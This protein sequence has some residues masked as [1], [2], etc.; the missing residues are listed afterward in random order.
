A[1]RAKLV[2]L[3]VTQDLL[4]ASNSEAKIRGKTNTR[5][6]PHSGTKRMAEGRSTQPFNSDGAGKGI[7]EV[8]TLDRK[9]KTR[10]VDWKRLLVYNVSELP[11]SYIKEA[12][13]KHTSLS[14]H[15]ISV[16]RCCQRDGIRRFDVVPLTRVKPTLEDLPRL[17][18][19]LRARVKVGKS[20]T[21]RMELARRKFVESGVLVH[22]PS[23][24]KVE[25]PC[26]VSF[27]T[28]NI[29]GLRLKLSECALLL[30]C[31]KPTIVCLQETLVKESA[32]RTWLPHYQTIETRAK[33]GSVRGMALAVMRDSGLD[34]S[35]YYASDWLLVGR[36]T[37]SL[38]GNVKID[39]LV[40]N[41]YIPCS[42]DKLRS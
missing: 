38:E 5:K 10:K 23:V 8:T 18:E 40:I 15:L 19:S 6:A 25:A 36:V 26:M 12:V 1:K 32:H 4:G 27:M 21:E 14:E 31:T 7:Q 29:N 35:Q 13:L 30:K 2:H 41:T 11:V 37:G 28:F 42:T 34:L 9:P 16:K 3:N 20:Y 22:K 17:E 33:G 24:K 39:M